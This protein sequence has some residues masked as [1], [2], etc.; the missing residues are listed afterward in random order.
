MNY[1]KYML[2]ISLLQPGILLAQL[3]SS[4]GSPHVLPLDGVTR[5][6]TASANTG[7]SVVCMNGNY[8][9]N[10]PVTWFSFTTNSSAE[11]PLL[12]ITT[13][14]SSSCEVAMYTACNGGSVLQT[15]SS[16]CFDD[17]WGLWTPAH[18]YNLLSNTT[19][20]LRIKTHSATQIRITGQNY[21]PTNSMCVGAT[22][23]D[24]VP[25]HDN[26]AAH[27]PS[28]E[29]TPGQLCAYTIE[30]TAFYQFYIASEG[31]AIINISR[32]ACDNGSYNN[33]NGIQ[34]GFFTGNCG[35][36][37]PL[38][39]NAGAGP[40]VQATTPVLNAGTRVYVAIDGNAGSNCQYELQAINAY[41]VL[42]AN[43]FKNF[44]IWKTSQS[45]LLKWIGIANDNSTF[46]VERSED[47]SSFITIGR[48]Y[49]NSDLKES[50]YQYEDEFPPS[51]GFYQIRRIDKNGR[52]SLS[53]TLSIERKEDK[54]LRL[55]FVNPVVNNLVVEIQS[56]SPAPLDY[57]VSSLF[58][59]IYLRGK[60]HLTMGTNRFQK[61]VSVLPK[62]Q[63]II[64]VSSNGTNIN[65]PFLKID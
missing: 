10:S 9:N 30:N 49:A 61:E 7:G 47:G 6:F 62:G 41:K 40:L 22:P 36:L 51:H 46:D 57:T 54:G 64:S 14:D 55:K 45:N 3:G 8:P 19:Y 39:C 48:V 25:V 29:V 23:V 58:G 35:A 53:N 44:S 28:A 43:E 50:S 37:I 21:T 2:V 63:Y 65:A 1:T 26:N 11:M 52:I 38:S 13:A 16:M 18:N 4:C 60:L 5:T 12:D 15:F 33:D 32:I 31:A 34:I 27:R 42:S 17:G 56:D 20:R 59:Q 24:A